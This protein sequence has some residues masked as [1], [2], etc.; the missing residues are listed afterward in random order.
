MSFAEAP[1]AQAPKGG[2]D[3]LR[4]QPFPKSS[5]YPLTLVACRF[6]KD[7]YDAQKEQTYDAVEMFFGTVIA[8]QAYFIATWPKKYSIHPKSAYSGIIRAL[9]GKDPE[10]GSKPSDFYGKAAL[11]TVTNK[12]KVS[13][14]GTAYTASY[15]TGQ[16]ELPEALAATVTPLEQLKDAFAAAVAPKNDEDA[17]F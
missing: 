7:Y 8:G 14:K 9:T 12:D 6:T 11:F 4:F 13:K 1:A 5:S 2:S 16:L 15:I 17:P 10:P 3:F